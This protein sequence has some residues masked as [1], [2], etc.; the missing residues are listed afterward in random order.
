MP[1][2]EEAEGRA[3]RRRKL[4]PE[5]ELEMVAEGEVPDATP[6]AI[7]VKWGVSKATYYNVRARVLADRQTA[8]SP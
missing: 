3:G 4:T 8:K 7:A 6:E 5:D 1:G 2:L